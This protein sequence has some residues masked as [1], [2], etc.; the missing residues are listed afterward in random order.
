MDAQFLLALRRLLP[1]L[2]LIVC[3]T[4]AMFLGFQLGSRPLPSSSG[5]LDVTVV[6]VG[7]GEA[8]WIRTPTGKFLLIGAG[9]PDQGEKVAASLRAA[10]ARRIDLLVL[11]YP[12]A[13]A[14]GGVPE[15]LR[16]FPVGQA[17]EP[18]FPAQQDL[19]VQE[20]VRRLLAGGNT[21]VAIARAGQRLAVGGIKIEVLAPG[22]APLSGSPRPANNSVVLRVV[23]GQTAFLFTGGLE[24]AGENALLGRAPELAAQWLR[25]AHFGTRE[26]TSPELLRLVRPSIAVIS[27]G[28][29]NPGGYPHRE[30]LERLRATG[31]RIW[32]TDERA[33]DLRFWSDGRRIRG[34][35]ANPP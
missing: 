16:Q 19:P 10:G 28:G 27:V 21:P 6:N 35:D 1:L 8:A 31:A 3:A 32:R 20:E 13:E 9:P 4:G 7:Q 33:D 25:V 12:Y 11:P 24:R 15:V 2:V 26:A 29:Q 30:T 18:G 5:R 34:P 14:I 22:E 17:L 23:Y